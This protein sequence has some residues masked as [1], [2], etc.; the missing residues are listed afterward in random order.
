MAL[1][2]RVKSK[3]EVPQEQL[4]FYV[5]RD[6][7]WVLDVEGGLGDPASVE[8]AQRANK[9]KLDK[10]RTANIAL[11][12]QVEDLTA[13]VAAWQQGAI[14]RDTL[15]HNLRAGELLPPAR[16]NEQ[17]V[18]LIGNGP[19]SRGSTINESDEKASEVRSR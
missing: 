14:S 13:L 16:T 5:E 2:P 15:L 17:E 7:A 4:P 1:K 11:R 12:K 6:G 3:E 9:A 19:A 8:E 10:F 18:E